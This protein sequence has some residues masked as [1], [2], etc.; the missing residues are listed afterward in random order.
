MESLLPSSTT[1][2]SVAPRVRSDIA[3]RSWITRDSMECSP[4]RTGRTTDIRGDGERICKIPMKAASSGA[5]PSVFRL[6]I[7]VASTVGCQMLDRPTE[8]LRFAHRSAANECTYNRG[9]DML[10]EGDFCPGFCV[11]V[12]PCAEGGLILTAVSAWVVYLSAKYRLP[13]ISSAVSRLP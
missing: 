9:Q 8:R 2:T 7:L 3:S 4:F 5:A 1:T 10:T 13:F 12:V 11:S 6:T